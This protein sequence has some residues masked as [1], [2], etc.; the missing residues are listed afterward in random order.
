M[1]GGL[2]AWLRHTFLVFLNYVVSYI[3]P[4]NEREGP[5]KTDRIV[6][7]EDRENY[8]INGGNGQPVYGSLS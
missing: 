3:G 4:E 5:V 2:H 8:I 1:P 6:R 7:C